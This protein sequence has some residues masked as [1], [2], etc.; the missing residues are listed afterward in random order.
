MSIWNQEV[1]SSNQGD[2]DTP[3]AGNHPAILVALIDL[4]T[5]RSE[6]QGK[7]KWQRRIY[8]V[9][10]LVEEPISGNED[11]NHVI[12]AVVTLSMN[13]K[14]KLRKWIESR[15][16]Q[17]LGDGT[18]YPVSEEV[19]KSCL[20]SVVHNEKGYA[21]VE[22]MSSLPKGMR[23]SPAKRQQ[24]CI[25]LEE[26]KSGQKKIPLYVPWIYGESVM[27]VIGYSKE[28]R[29]ESSPQ[30]KDTTPDT[31]DEDKAPSYGD[32]IPF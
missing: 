17:T 22:G 27:D 18:S 29:G 12:G 2:F 1:T 7:V 21:R 11:Q 3:P 13:S 30:D 8:M 20:L 28:I 9:W 4:G 32:D 19:G 5:Q 26:C 6:Y 15:L 24:V 10:E 14:S 25:S 31:T 16:N 23:F